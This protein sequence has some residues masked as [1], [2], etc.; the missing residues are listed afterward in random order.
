VLL[1]TISHVMI[2][3]LVSCRLDQPGLMRV[4]MYIKLAV[5]GMV[6]SHDAGAETEAVLLE[7]IRAEPSGVF[8]YLC[9]KCSYKRGEALYTQRQDVYYTCTS[10]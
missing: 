2:D 9:T 6:L 4:G 10:L 3:V 7:D 1:R 8:F 5:R